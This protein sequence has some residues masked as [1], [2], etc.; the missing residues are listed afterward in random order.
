[1]LLNLTVSGIFPRSI[2]IHTGLNPN[3]KPGLHYHGGPY[4]PSVICTIKLVM[5][6]EIAEQN[7]P[8]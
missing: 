1:M 7:V 8:R 2:P 6:M 5:K 3:L 4:Q